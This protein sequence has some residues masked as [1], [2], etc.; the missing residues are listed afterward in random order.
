MRSLSTDR[1][2]AALP[3]ASFTSPWGD[4]QFDVP[5]ITAGIA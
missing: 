3:Q 5:L 4:Q 1:S 2:Q